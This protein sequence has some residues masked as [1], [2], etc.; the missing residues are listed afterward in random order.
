[1][2]E[3]P[4]PQPSIIPPDAS[5]RAFLGTAAASLAAMG[6]AGFAPTAHAANSVRR[7]GTSSNFDLFEVPFEN[8]EYQPFELDYPYNALEEAIDEKTMDLH[9]RIHTESYRGGLN[10]ALKE[11]AAARSADNFDQIAHWQN[12]LAFNGAGFMLHLVF[13]RNLAP[14]G[15][16]RPSQDFRQLMDKHFGGLD[17][18]KKHFSAAARTVQGSGWAI[19]GYQP[20]GDQFVILQV[21]KHQNHTLWG[22]IPILALDVWEHA[23]YLRYQNRRPEYVDNFWKVVNWDNLEARATAARE[24]LGTNT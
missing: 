5:R 15:A 3:N 2:T 18:M 22:V 1:M 7:S 8:G 13:F 11:L 9:H 17:A 20:V 24:L 14:A 12:Q 10:K 19:L 23:Y 6:L 16:S 4:T 21:E